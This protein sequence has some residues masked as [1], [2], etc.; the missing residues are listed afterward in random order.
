MKN[1]VE[2]QKKLREAI[3]EGDAAKIEK[4]IASGAKVDEPDENRFTPLMN[5]IIFCNPAAVEILLSHGANP[6]S[7]ATGNEG[8]LHMAINIWG[9][10]HTAQNK[11]EIV[12]RLIEA[13]ADTNARGSMGT[14]ALDEAY[15]VL[16]QMLQQQETL[17]FSPD[18]TVS[19]K[20]QS[21]Q[22]R[23]E[24]LN[25]LPEIIEMLENRG[26]DVTEMGLVSKM[27]TQMTPKERERLLKGK[28]SGGC[29]GVVLIALG[30][31][32]ALATLWLLG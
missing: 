13:G 17:T 31:I 18:G 22:Q 7:K 11:I 32:L 29:A 14:T 26:A 9:G 8:L 15:T 12:R 19:R 2:M 3:L 16:S 24:V 5:A 1:L 28:K 21:E 4:M 6:N 20:Q 27:M 30:V 10:K 25:S 23:S